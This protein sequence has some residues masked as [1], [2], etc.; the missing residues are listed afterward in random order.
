MRASHKAVP[1]E[2]PA[3]LGSLGT[4]LKVK[5]SRGGPSADRT[6]PRNCGVSALTAGEA[7]RQ[8][9]TQSGG[10]AELL[11]CQELIGFCGGSQTAP[12]VLAELLLRR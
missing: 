3:A 10:A 7:A 1:P 9:E 4:Q 12:L 2:P 6:Q 5:C 8:R 11:L